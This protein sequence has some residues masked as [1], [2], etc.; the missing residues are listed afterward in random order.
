MA[1]LLTIGLL[2]SK[3][4]LRSIKNAV[5]NNSIFNDTG[6]TSK[7]TTIIKE[8][9]NQEDL[10]DEIESLF[11]LLMNKVLKYLLENNEFDIE[12]LQYYL[13]FLKIT[14]NENGQFNLSDNR[15]SLKMLNVISKYHLKDCLDLVSCVHQFKTATYKVDLQKYYDILIQLS[16]LANPIC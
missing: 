16:S 1:S 14:I 12:A 7:K 10:T 5:W 8:C 9:D 4:Y 6:L 11:E 13:G 3:K 15:N 2:H